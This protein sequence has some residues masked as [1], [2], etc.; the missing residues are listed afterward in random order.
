MSFPIE[1]GLIW[2]EEASC[3]WFYD[4]S[5]IKRVINSSRKFVLF[6]HKQWWEYER[7]QVLVD[8]VYQADSSHCSGEKRGR[9]RGGSSWLR[10]VAGSLLDNHDGSKLGFYD[11]LNRIV[12]VRA[13]K[14]EPW[15]WQWDPDRG[16]RVGYG[17]RHSPHSCSPC[18]QS[19]HH[20]WNVLARMWERTTQRYHVLALLGLS[21]LEDYLIRV[22][23]MGLMIPPLKA[24]SKIHAAIPTRKLRNHQ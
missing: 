9:E 20:R 11:H 2:C 24:P 7:W 23:K 8:R 18:S 5:N 10:Q 17:R 13:F 21:C 6:S 3:W 4:H 12:K 15:R 14:P 16:A 19:H 1:Y 22:V